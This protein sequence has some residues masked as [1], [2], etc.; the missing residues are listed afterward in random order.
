MTTPAAGATR[1]RPDSSFGKYTG[2]LEELGLSCRCA[3]Q[4]ST[5]T[6]V[7][8]H[9]FRDDTIAWELCDRC[10]RVVTERRDPPADLMRRA[11]DHALQQIRTLQDEQAAARSRLAQL[12][13]P[14]APPAHAASS[15]A[16]LMLLE[17][18]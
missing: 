18:A 3:Y 2:A 15:P 14:A 6:M 11:L 7:G 4:P 5:R 17:P 13:D 10:D 1:G 9:P 12:E 16:R 8:P